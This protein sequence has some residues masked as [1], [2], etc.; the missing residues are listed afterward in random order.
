[1]MT[2][3]RAA[4]LSLC[5]AVAAP[6]QTPLPVVPNRPS[7]A[8]PS[9]ARVLLPDDP[10]PILDLSLEEA[11][12][13]LGPP[14]NVLAVRGNEP[15]QDDVAFEYGEGFL[16]YWYRGRPWQI[17]LSGGYEGSCFGFFLGDSPDK[18]L[19]LLGSTDRSEA[20]TLEWRLPWRGYPVR[21]R[22]LVRDGAV[23]EA[24]VYRSDY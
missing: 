13:R 16:V 21:L 24:Y 7:E 10:A 12:N 20:D 1:M 15:W 2:R 11:W 3:S 14:K 17:R 18:V 23:S 6:A 9:P 22:I 19:S 8:A 4:L 5:L